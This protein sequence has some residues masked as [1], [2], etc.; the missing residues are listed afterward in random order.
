MATAAHALQHDI[1]P[2]HEGAD[3]EGTEAENAV[4]LQEKM[5]RISECFDRI[6]QLKD[7]RKQTQAEIQAARE[8]IV[9]LGI[10]KKAFDMALAYSKMDEEQRKGFDT[11]YT[12]VRKA[13]GL[14]VQAELFDET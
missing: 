8:E 3:T 10:P 5:N 1:E 4:D 9:A 12:L 14:P 13:I 2:D 7:E 11:A 6:E